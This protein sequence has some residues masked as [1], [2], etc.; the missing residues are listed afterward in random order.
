MTTPAAAPGSLKSLDFFKQAYSARVDELMAQR[1]AGK[2]VLGTF[3]LFVPDEIIFAAGAD[4]AILCGGRENTIPLGEQYLPRNVCPLIKS[5]FGSVVGGCAGDGVVCPHFR[6]V[7]AVIG[8]STCDGKKKMYELMRQFIPTYL[9]DLPQK[10]DTPAAFRYYLSELGDFCGYLEQ[11]TGNSIT[12]D[13][14]REEIRSGNEV[15]RLMQCLFE[16]RKADQPPVTGLEILQVTQ[17][18]FFLSPAQMKVGVA[19][20]CDELE[21]RPAGRRGPRILISGC[22]MSAGNVKVPRIVEERGAVIVAEES[23]TGTRAF[24]DLVDESKP[25]LEA[26]AERYLRIPCSCM[27]PNDR[28]I[29]RILSLARE[30]R[31]DGVIHYSLQSCHGYNVERYK[32]QQAL[33]DAGIPMLAIE[34]DYSA[35]DVEQLRVRIDAFLEMIE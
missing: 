17:R 34:T 25:P 22:P 2:K 19:Q 33:S 24:D 16:Y 11:L 6:A 28:R 26:L 23:C 15:R 30:Y 10:P 4:R 21:A 32:V 13:R 35:S 7:D 3:C 18:Q 9:I 20:L 29:D 5:S 31:A 27:T 14:L 1:Q 8:E 12:D